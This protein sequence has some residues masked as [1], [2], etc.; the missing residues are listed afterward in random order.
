[1]A[2]SPDASSEQGAGGPLQRD[3]QRAHDQKRLLEAFAACQDHDLGNLDGH[4][5]AVDSKIT[6]VWICDGTIRFRDQGGLSDVCISSIRRRSDGIDAE[7]VYHEDIDDPG[8]AAGAYLY[9]S[10]RGERLAI[11]MEFWNDPGTRSDFLVLERKR[12][13]SD[14]PYMKC[15]QGFLPKPLPPFL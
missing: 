7:A 15:P 5:L 14:Q 10:H 1:M 6:D 2:Q 4:W 3:L 13:P 12:E 11:E 8:D 9:F